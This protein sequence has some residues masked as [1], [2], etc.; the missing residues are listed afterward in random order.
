MH[1]LYV[2]VGREALLRRELEKVDSLAARLQL[3]DAEIAEWH[4]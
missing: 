2:S 1:E 3:P 4:S